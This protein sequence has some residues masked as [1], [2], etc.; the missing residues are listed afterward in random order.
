MALCFKYLLNE[1]SPK[2]KQKLFSQDIYGIITKLL[3]KLFLDAKSV[4][5]IYLH[6]LQIINILYGSCALYMYTSFLKLV[7][8]EPTVESY[9][10]AECR[11]EEIKLF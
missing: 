4:I 9:R 5:I 10:K 2:I 6:K 7:I 3:L 1:L 8:F 11:L